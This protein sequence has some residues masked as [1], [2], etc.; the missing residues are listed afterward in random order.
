MFVHWL[1]FVELNHKLLEGF[2]GWSNACNLHPIDLRKGAFVAAFNLLDARKS[3][4]DPVQVLGSPHPHPNSM[5]GTT[6]ALH[7]FQ[8]Q[9]WRE[10]VSLSAGDR[11]IR[12]CI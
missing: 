2:V 7:F 11:G 10:A 5:K 8:G 9:G 3:I 1:W 4:Y 6:R 12:P